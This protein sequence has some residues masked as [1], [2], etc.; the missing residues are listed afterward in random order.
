MSEDAKNCVTLLVTKSDLTD[1]ITF[2][3]NFNDFAAQGQEAL[4]FKLLKPM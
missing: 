4:K 1:D 2:Q 3:D